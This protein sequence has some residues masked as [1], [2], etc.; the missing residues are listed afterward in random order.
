MTHVTIVGSGD[1]GQAIAGVITKGGNTAELLGRSDA[2][3]P[4]TGDIAVLAVPYPALA[5]VLATCGD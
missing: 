4:V 5:G 2:G 3:K 1:M